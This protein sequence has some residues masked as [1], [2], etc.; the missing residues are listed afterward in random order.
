LKVLTTWAGAVNDSDPCANFYTHSESRSSITAKAC[1][2][3]RLSPLVS[4][5]RRPC[6]TRV[7]A[8]V[9]GV[10]TC[11]TVVLRQARL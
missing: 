8:G 10:A 3:W 2:K 4:P 1:K 7:V 9:A 6:F 5:C 11:L